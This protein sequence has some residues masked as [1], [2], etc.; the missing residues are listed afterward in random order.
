MFSPFQ[1]EVRGVNRVS[2]T[3]QYISD[4]T[5]P[6]NV[7]NSVIASGS[8]TELNTEFLERQN[9][10]LRFGG[11]PAETHRIS[12][13]KQRSTPILNSVAKIAVYRHFRFNRISKF[14]RCF[15]FV[16]RRC[17]KFTASL[18]S[19]SPIRA[20]QLPYNNNNVW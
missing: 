2:R 10:V 9:L 19:K 14:Q 20:P 17:P 11:G 16:K 12:R 3:K 15:W 7:E 8:K 1:K 18:R 4:E 13:E 5:T 6:R